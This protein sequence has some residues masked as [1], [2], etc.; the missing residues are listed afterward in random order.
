[1]VD[2]PHND[3]ARDAIVG[4]Y[5]EVRKINPEWKIMQTGNCNIPELIGLVDIWCPISNLAWRPFFQ[6]RLAEG[7]VLWQYVCITPKY[8]Y[9]NFFI[10][11]PG[12]NHRNLFWQ[13][14]KIN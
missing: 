5:Q 7:D 13:T 4:I 3:I 14:R 1:G 2:E 8:P 10:D 6:E 9:A 11:E 12:T